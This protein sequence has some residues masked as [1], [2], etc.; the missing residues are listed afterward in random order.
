MEEKL[1]VFKVTFNTNGGDTIEPVEVEEGQR[2][3]KP[4]DPVRS[5]YTF[6]GWFTKEGEYDFKEEA[7]SKYFRL[8]PG[9]EVRLR[10]SYIIIFS[11]TSIT[12]LS[13]TKINHFRI[14]ILII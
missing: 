1:K 14:F 5:G 2:V 9:K 11:K 10:Y 3:K 4:A 6:I 7:T 12:F 8:A 13:F